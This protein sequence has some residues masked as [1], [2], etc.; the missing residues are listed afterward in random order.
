M[1]RVGAGRIVGVAVLLVGTVSL[2][3]CVTQL[4]EPANEVTGSQHTESTWVPGR[5]AALGEPVDESIVRELMTEDWPGFEV[6]LS[7]PLAYDLGPFLA[8]SAAGGPRLED[9]I[10]EH[11]MVTRADPDLAIGA[12]YNGVIYLIDLEPSEELNRLVSERLDLIAAQG[13]ASMSD[14]DRRDEPNSTAT[15]P[16]L[17]IGTATA[18]LVIAGED[19]RARLGIVDGFSETH[20]YAPIGQF[21]V[22]LPPPDDAP[23]ASGTL[24]APHAVL[25]AAHILFADG[26]GAN[27]LDVPLKF[28]PRH[29]TTKAIPLVTPNPWNPAPWGS[30]PQS[31][32]RPEVFPIQYVLDGCWRDTESSQPE[33]RARC[34]EN[35][36]AMLD[37]DRTTEAA[38]LPTNRI[39]RYEAVP[40]REFHW[41]K[42]RGYPNCG[43]PG[44]PVDKPDDTC[45]GGTLY[46]DDLECTITI[47]EGRVDHG[48]DTIA[49][50]DCDTNG[51][52][53]GS[54]LYMYRNIVTPTIIGIHTHDCSVGG[55]GANCAFFDNA[56]AVRMITADVVEELNNFVLNHP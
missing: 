11:R 35:D 48:L 10:P 13:L 44:H 38:G 27:P 9:L 29:D 32:G 47:F 41:L 42:N 17:D 31:A 53:S 22:D 52:Q 14:A 43:M 1:Q 50:H 54:P 2:Q 6:G 25:T 34:R 28:A 37:V 4:D 19:S 39:F 15:H 55:G 30:W 56:N 23:W 12:R 21:S 46:G 40:P 5:Y 26:G 51:G 18:A 24:V 7:L 45:T 8:A 49:R 16:E 36:W 3:G 33:V 20:L